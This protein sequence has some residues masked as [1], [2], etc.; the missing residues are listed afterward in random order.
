MSKRKKEGIPTEI[1]DLD[2]YRPEE[3][4]QDVVDYTDAYAV[5]LGEERR[6]SKRLTKI[7][8][9]FGVIALSLLCAYLVFLVIGVISTKYYITDD[10]V[11]M[12]VIAGYQTLQAREDYNAV[13]DQMSEIRDILRDMTIIDI[14][15]A[16]EDIS[17]AEAA[18]QYTQ[19]LNDQVDILIPRV[20]AMD[21][22]DNN[23]LIRQQMESLLAND[24]AIYL[25][26]ITAALQS[27]D[28]TAAQEALAWRE[29]AFTSFEA[30]NEN[31][32]AL[33]QGIHEENDAFWEWTLN[34]AVVEKDPT[35]ILD[36]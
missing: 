15:V 17:Y 7:R 33:A 8:S 14:K 29:S 36:D 25:Q 1:I 4:Y 31:V 19:L 6:K 27:S 11:N 22:T 16:N 21:V 24:I 9:Y 23:A 10:N 13:K 12:P 3:S 28:A 20:Q 2:N 35:A 30:L 34:E 18:V 32:F 26:N 5:E